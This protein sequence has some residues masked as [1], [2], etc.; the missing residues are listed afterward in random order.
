M[1][2]VLAALSQSQYRS[3][4]QN[5]INDLSNWTIEIIRAAMNQSYPL[6]RNYI[7]DTS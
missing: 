3:Q 2:R 5:Q 1:S 4:M 7:N 6:L